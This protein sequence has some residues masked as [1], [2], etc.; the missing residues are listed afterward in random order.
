MKKAIHRV[1]FKIVFLSLTLSCFAVQPDYPEVI[2]SRFSKIWHVAPQEKIYLHTDKPYLYSAGD[3]IWFRAHLVNA[4]TLKPNTR[5]NFAY[6]EL[7]DKSD[8]VISRVKVKRDK[9]GLAGK[10]TLPPEIAAGEYILRA[11][12]YWMQNV[13]EDF[14]FHKKIYIGNSIDDR[15]LVNY[16][17]GS[18]EKG[19]IP[20]TITFTN[21]FSTPLSQK[22]VT[23]NH[24]HTRNNKQTTK[25]ITNQQGEI[26][27]LVKSDSITNKKKF[28][29][30]FLDEPGLK[31][32]RKIQLPETNNDFDLQFFPESGIFLN[33]QLQMVAF[34]AIGK[35]GLS[36]E[37]S[38]KIYNN[39][40][41][42][43]SEFK[44]FNKGM[45]KIYLRTF[46]NE[47]YYAIVQNESGYEKRVELPATTS[48]GIA[49]KMGA[50]RGKTYYEVLNQTEISNDDLFLMIHVRGIVYLV[51]QLN[52][53]SGYFSDDFLPAGICSFSI[54]D[55]IGNT[56]CERLGFVRNFNFP[57]ISMKSD[58]DKYGKREPVKMDFSVLNTDSLPAKGSFSV[59]VTD[60][61]LVQTDSINDHLLSYLLLSGDIKGYVE[62]PQQYFADNSTLT[63]E[64]TDILML[65]QGWRR[66]N[67]ADI[68][69]AKYPQPQY[70]LEAGQTVSGKVFNLFNKPVNNSE[71]IYLSTYKNQINITKTDSTGQFIIDGIE[72][73]DST[74]IILK[75]KSRSKIVDVELVTDNDI[76]PVTENNIPLRQE[77][78]STFHDEYLSL[79]K[80]KYY[81]EGG[82]LVV[83]LDE[84]TVN[85]ETKS[86][87]ADNYYS[88]MADNTMDATTLEKYSSYR[89]LDLIS[90]MPGVQVSGQN[91]IIRGA[92]QS[93][94]FVVDG[95]ETESI[96]DIEFLNATDV[97]EIALFKGPSA[98]IFGL[99][100]GNG[101]IAITLKKG[102]TTQSVTPASLAHISP[103]GYQKPA[104]FYVPKYE[105]DS[106]LQQP[107]SDLRTTIYWAPK[108]QTD[109]QGKIQLNFYTAD[110]ANDYNVELEG[111]TEQGEICRYK[112]I[113]KRE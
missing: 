44:T 54:I 56:Y 109:E 27:L 79:S 40:Q 55:S 100:G 110:K 68:L 69:K 48:K 107:R 17:F 93:A 24:A 42:E 98:S 37:V 62:D 67:T 83:N 49:L 14:F 6:V 112:A 95:I 105:V 61:K 50:N 84:F 2:A 59:S 20:L 47:S 46:P 63:R 87:S 65:T 90:M 4:A 19:K 1:L 3:D 11:Y 77:I 34:K 74:H 36:S 18:P 70:Y 99:R 23:V 5:S 85:A 94:L 33:D 7:I 25:H 102:V 89:V 104:E 78:S 39:K 66:F 76:F 32:T 88:G 91:V 41:E 96:E 82:M 53:N 35:D 64:K 80:E 111:V 15:V 51:K 10:L 22:N 58:K 43:I 92:S 29:E 26:S 81:N 101:V 86:T 75:A 12:T 38:G 13:S 113:L 30:I 97:E 71:V 103:L 9:A 45:G 72:F 73:P 57:A 52:E 60:S 21:T 31:L 8:S 16:R 106:I 108:V 28:I